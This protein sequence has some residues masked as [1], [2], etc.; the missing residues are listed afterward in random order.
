MES[1]LQASVDDKV[2]MIPPDLYGTIKLKEEVQI[3]SDEH[4][5]YQNIPISQT[6]T[7]YKISGLS[8]CLSGIGDRD[9][10]KE[11]SFYYCRYCN[12]FRCFKCVSA[13]ILIS[14]FDNSRPNPHFNVINFQMFLRIR[15]MSAMESGDDRYKDKG[16]VICNQGQSISTDNKQ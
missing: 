16:Y 14:C 12:H 6:R 8:K 13:D 9:M 2:K 5:L 1:F 3:Y 7:C 11:V 10:S 15:L 4:K